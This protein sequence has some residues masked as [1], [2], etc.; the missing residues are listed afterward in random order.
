MNAKQI[1]I[2]ILWFDSFEQKF[3]PMND[4]NN[5]GK[6]YIINPDTQA[7][8]YLIPHR[9]HIMLTC[10]TCNID[11]SVKVTTEHMEEF[12]AFLKKYLLHPAV[13]RLF[14]SN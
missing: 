10:Y 7:R 13:F 2:G 1:C 6:K 14:T 3:M 12:R 5:P 11:D 4:N 9:E 8:Y